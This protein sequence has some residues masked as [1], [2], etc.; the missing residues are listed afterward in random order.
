MSSLNIREFATIGL[1]ERVPEASRVVGNAIPVQSVITGRRTQKYLPVNGS[2]FTESQNP[3]FKMSANSDFLIPSSATLHFKLKRTSAGANA[4][5][6]DVPALAVINRAILRASGVLV[7]DILEV[8]RSS[9]AMTYSHM[10]PERYSGQGSI[11]TGNWKWNTAYGSNAIAALPSAVVGVD[12]AN[13]TVAE[14]NTLATPLSTYVEGSRPDGKGVAQR[15]TRASA[16]YAQD[17]EI[18][19]NLP[20]SYIFGT[21]RT[22]KLFP[23]SF[24]GQLEIELTLAQALRALVDKS[25]V[26]ASPSYQITDTY[27]IADMAQL[28][29]DYLKVLAQSFASPEPSMAYNLPVDTLTNI[30]QNKSVNSGG[31]LNSYVYSKSTPFLKAILFTSQDNSQAV[32]TYSTSGMP[33]LLADD[34]CQ[35]RLFIGSETFPQYGVLDTAKEVFRHNMVGL[36]AQGNV[37]AQMGLAT[38][39]NFTDNTDAGGINYTLFSFA[40]VNGLGEEYY[41]LDSYDASLQGAVIDYQVKQKHPSITSASNLAVIE[42]TRILRI[43]GGRLEVK[44]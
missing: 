24:V 19:V 7:E 32:T 25:G 44:A 1:D 13:P 16:E 4:C 39:E 21:F 22:N 20:L 31:L 28:S 12:P 42:H 8:G 11:D 41:D 15:Q 3:T 14:I 10:S 18:E 9:V 5:F 27:I 33:N 35:V 36:G 6:D 38:H 37:Q 34:G 30:T 17:A 43:G 40:K 26:P 29:D 2:T 23:L